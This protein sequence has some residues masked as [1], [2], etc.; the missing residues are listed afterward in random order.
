MYNIRIM[1]DRNTSVQQLS[2]LDQVP[3]GSDPVRGFYTSSFHEFIRISPLVAMDHIGSIFVPNYSDLN[4]DH[5]EEPVAAYVAGQFE[6][7]M[8]SHSGDLKYFVNRLEYLA[9]VNSDMVFSSSES[10]VPVTYGPYDPD[11]KRDVRTV[12]NPVY[13]KV[14]MDRVNPVR[15]QYGQKAKLPTTYTTTSV[16]VEGVNLMAMSEGQLG[17]KE[18]ADLMIGYLFCCYCGKLLQRAKRIISYIE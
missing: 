14:R 6:T 10:E 9:L 16:I 1:P 7:Y 12:L 8:Q 17:Q 4:L 15:Y 13:A 2:F 3:L 11:L 5:I 18:G